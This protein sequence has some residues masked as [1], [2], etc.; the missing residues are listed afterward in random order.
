MIEIAS[1]PKLFAVRPRHFIRNT[2]VGTYDGWS[3]NYN[4][5]GI[6]ASALEGIDHSKSAASANDLCMGRKIV[7]LVGS[8]VTVRT[9]TQGPFPV[10]C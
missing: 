8:R 5:S 2:T 3:V 6:T 10:K 9:T 4:K 7:V 1:Q